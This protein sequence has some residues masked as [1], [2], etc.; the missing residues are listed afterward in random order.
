MSGEPRSTARSMVQRAKLPVSFAGLLNDRG[1]E[2]AEAWPGRQGRGAGD[3]LNVALNVA[4]GLLA[5]DA[6]RAVV[7]AGLDPHIG[8]LHS[9]ARNKP[10]LALDLMEE[11]RPVVADSVVVGAINNGELRTSMFS[12]ALGDARLRD[13]GRRALI[14][15]YERRMAT[16][17]THPLFKYKVTWRRAM[18]VQAR[19]VLGVLDG[20]RMDYR[21]IVTR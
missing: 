7:A 14:A 5:A 1:R 6:V 13:N 8:V 11:F 19:M 20:T 21:G 12:R 2:F 4:Y 17:F 16:E 10:A 18:E 9:S 15:C 3:P